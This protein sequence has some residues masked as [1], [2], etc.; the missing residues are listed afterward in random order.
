MSE[1]E[2]AAEFATAQNSNPPTTVEW[3]VEVLVNLGDFNNIKIGKRLGD[4]VR[5][6]ETHD[7]ASKRVFDSV[8]DDVLEKAREAKAGKR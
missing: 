8:W 7:Q 4:Y 6:G 3:S 2:R 5:Q 1:L